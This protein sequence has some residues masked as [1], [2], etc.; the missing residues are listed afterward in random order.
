VVVSAV[1]PV[2]AFGRSV[3]VLKAIKGGR[4]EKTCIT[5]G[6]TFLCFRFEKE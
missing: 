6:R 2:Q 1:D 5:F 3:N 4:I